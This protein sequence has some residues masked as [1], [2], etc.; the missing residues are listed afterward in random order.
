MA[1]FTNN[2]NN[3]NKRQQQL[4]MKLVIVL[5]FVLFHFLANCFFMYVIQIVGFSK[6]FSF[7]FLSLFFGEKPDQVKGD[8]AHL[9]LC[10]IL[11]SYIKD[12]DL[13]FCCC[14]FGRNSPA[15]LVFLFFFFLLMMMIIIIAIQP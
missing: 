14:C 5:C 8:L 2:K 4:L 13:L 11:S 3:N 1:I 6:Q 15:K 12:S 7:F 9:L 10:T